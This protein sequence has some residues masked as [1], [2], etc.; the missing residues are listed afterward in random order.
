VIDVNRTGN[1][2]HGARC[3]SPCRRAT[4]PCRYF[5]FSFNSGRWFF[6]IFLIRDAYAKMRDKAA[7]QRLRL[8]GFQLL[9]FG[10]RSGVRD[11]SRFVRNPAR[12]TD[13]PES[14][15]RHYPGSRS[16]SVT[17]GATHLKSCKN[18]RNSAFAGIPP[19]LFNLI[20][21]LFPLVPASC[22]GTRPLHSECTS[23]F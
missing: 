18:V 2:S 19:K 1:R 13:L 22:G 14:N 17:R 4:L 20:E 7:C 9:L 21:S 10:N 6:C 8:D 5:C 16:G 15:Y 3:A 11:R 23:E 12:R